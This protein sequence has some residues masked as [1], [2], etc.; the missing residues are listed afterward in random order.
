MSLHSSLCMTCFFRNTK[1]RLLVAAGCCSWLCRL[2]E[3]DASLHRKTELP[4]QRLM[5]LLLQGLKLLPLHGLHPDDLAALVLLRLTRKER[6]E[7]RYTA[8]RLWG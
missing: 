1:F 6:L 5:V 3:L 7:V 2:Q 4:L 8:L